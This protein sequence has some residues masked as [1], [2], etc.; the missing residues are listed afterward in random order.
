M[1]Y[2]LVRRG[3]G[4]QGRAVVAWFAEPVVGRRLAA[5]AAALRQPQLQFGAARLPLG[6]SCPPREAFCW[7]RE[8]ASVSS[9]TVMAP[10]DA[11]G[12]P[13]CGAAI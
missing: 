1:E 5:V 7:L 13:L 2:H 11:M 4:P 3:R 6:V 12:S 8:A 10:E 9:C